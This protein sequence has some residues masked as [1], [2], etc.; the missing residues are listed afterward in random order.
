MKYYSC[1]KSTSFPSY[2][3]FSVE[4]FSGLIYEHVEYDVDF[5]SSYISKKLYSFD[6]HCS[7]S[8]Y[9]YKEISFELYKALLH[10][11]FSSSLSKIIHL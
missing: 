8:P 9:Q 3:F 5:I 1:E 6:A 4:P 7:K 2:E 10:S 11:A